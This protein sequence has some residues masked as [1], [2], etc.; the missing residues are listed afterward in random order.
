MNI[1][2]LEK[3]EKIATL[4]TGDMGITAQFGPLFDPKAGSSPVARSTA[5]SGCSTSPQW[6]PGQRRSTPSCSIR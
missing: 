6:S 3:G 2:D 5:L 1:Y 4:N